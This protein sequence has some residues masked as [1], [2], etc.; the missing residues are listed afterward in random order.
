MNIPKQN[1]FN[2]S[3]LEI[4]DKSNGVL[5]Y[6][7]LIEALTE[8][9]SLNESDFQEMITGGRQTVVYNRIAWAT[10]ELKRAGLLDSPARGSFQINSE[11]HNYLRTQGDTSTSQLRKRRIRLED[12]QN[13]SEGAATPDLTVTTDAPE[14]EEETDDNPTELIE[15]VYKQ[16]KDALTDDMLDALK[17]VPPDRFEQ[18]VVDLLV[19]MGYGEGERQGGSGDGGIDGIINQDPLG[20]EKVYIQAKRWQ[21]QVPEPEIRNFSGS[22]DARG[23]SKGVFITTSGFGPSARQTAQNISAGG[24][25]IRLIDGAELSRLMIAHNVGVVPETTYV[26]KKLDENYFSEEV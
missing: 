23:A 13:Y 9:F 1:Q 15:N 14:I 3:V 7:D 4:A 11:G 5:S 12:Q 26:I 21:N 10:G 2:R 18:L 16:L 25:F 22:L 20:L 19:K 17:G 6:K 8:R 24:K